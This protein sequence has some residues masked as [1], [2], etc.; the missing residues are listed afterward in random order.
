MWMT[1]ILFT[2][3]AGFL[4]LGPVNRLGLPR[5]AEIGIGLV[6]LLLPQ[7]YL[8]IRIFQTSIIS[9]DAVP[10]LLLLAVFLGSAFLLVATGAEILRL[11]L[12]LVKVKLP[13]WTSLSLGLLGAIFLIL[14]GLRQPGIIE[15]TLTLSHLPAEAE[16]LRVAV[17][18]DL[19]ID[20]MRGKKWCERFVSR[21][22]AAKP[23]IIL[24]TGDQADG[25]LEL[26]KPDLLP[27]KKLTPHAEKYLITGNH[28]FYFET[29]AYM[30]YYRELGIR[31]IDSTC[32]TTHGLAILGLPDT[33]SLTQSY[34]SESHIQTLTRDI[35]AETPTILLAHKPAV[36]AIADRY[37]ID[38]QFSGHTHGGQLPLMDLLIARMNAGFVR[39]WYKL[40]RGLKLYV[41]T[42]AGVWIGFPYR[43]FQPEVKI[44][45]LKGENCASRKKGFSTL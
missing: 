44:F 43:F 23:D 39:G 33:R 8:L 6:L 19:H 4:A 5:W 13:A 21:V 37:E 30:N 40:P 42:G 45:I 32:V 10:P 41:S 38:V 22:N 11:L 31:P 2:L 34:M 24:F 1:S 25:A 7:N 17:I 27:L 14:S 3:F 18:A 20:L 16:G 26:R 28:E 12:F 15:E 35:P 9:P 36:A 29:E